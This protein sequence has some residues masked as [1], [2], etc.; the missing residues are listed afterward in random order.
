MDMG[1]IVPRR[2]LRSD[3]ERERRQQCVAA[4]PDSAPA[5]PQERRPAKGAHSYVYHY[6]SEC[7]LVSPCYAAVIALDT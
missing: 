4:A 3:S 2:R 7:A 1:N 6:T 5:D